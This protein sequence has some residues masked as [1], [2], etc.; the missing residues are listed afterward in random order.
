MKAAFI[1]GIAIAGMLLLPL[2]GVVIAEEASLGSVRTGIFGLEAQ[3]RR[4][5]YV[6]DR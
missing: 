1:T 6:F 5:V 3:G 4:F 2:A